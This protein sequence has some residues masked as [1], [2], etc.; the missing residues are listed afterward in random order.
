M[1]D[2]LTGSSVRECRSCQGWQREESPRSSAF[3]GMY[4][5]E[6]GSGHI[7]NEEHFSMALHLVIVQP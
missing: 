6:N 7:Q 1:K 2:S 5:K 4:N 3:S